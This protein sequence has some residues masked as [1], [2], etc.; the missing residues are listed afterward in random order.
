MLF[1]LFITVFFATAEFHRR[2]HVLMQKELRDLQA[3]LASEAPVEAAL[4]AQL[5]GEDW[6][7]VSLTGTEAGLRRAFEVPEREAVL[8]YAVPVVAFT[9]MLLGLQ[10]W[11]LPFL[12][13]GV[14]ALKW[15]ASLTVLDLDPHRPR[16][17]VRLFGLRLFGERLD[18]DDIG[19]QH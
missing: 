13:A 7:L 2:E 12:Y 17:E 3:K 19:L 15:F 11:T 16:Y 1:F 18:K 5:Q 4:R 10:N 9:I 8:R 14:M 6:R